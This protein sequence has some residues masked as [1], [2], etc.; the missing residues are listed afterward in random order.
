MDSVAEIT[1]KQ[2]LRFN[3]SIKDVRDV[4]DASQQFALSER[5]KKDNVDVSLV[6]THKFLGEYSGNNPQ[7][8]SVQLVDGKIGEGTI[9]GN[10]I[11]IQQPGREQAILETRSFIEP[12]LKDVKVGDK[13]KVAEEL[14]T[15]LTASTVLHEGVHGMLDS[16]PGSKFAS[17][18]EAVTGFLNEQ[19]RASTLLDEGI[20]YAIQGIYAPEIE[21]IG[22]LA[23]V[24][25]YTDERAIRQRKLLGEKLKP[26][27]KEYIDDG[28]SIDTEFF[29][30]AGQFVIEIQ[31]QDTE[32]E[33]VKSN[34]LSSFSSEELR[35]GA[36]LPDKISTVSWDV[37]SGDGGI[38]ELIE[39]ARAGRPI[40]EIIEEAVKKGSD[41]EVI[42]IKQELIAFFGKDKESE[43]DELLASDN[44][45]SF[46]IALRKLTGREVTTKSKMDTVVGRALEVAAVVSDATDN[47]YVILGSMSM[48]LTLSEIRKV[49]EKLAL[50]DQ[51]ISGGKNDFDIGVHPEKI[52]DTMND[53]GWDDKAQKLRRGKVGINNQTVDMLS[54]RELPHFPWQEVHIGEKSCIV[55]STEEMI[56]EKMML[57]I[58]PGIEE[59]GQQRTREIKWGIDIKLLKTYLR[60]KKGWSEEKVDEHLTRRWDEYM[61]DVGGGEFN[62]QLSYR[63]ASRVAADEY[64]KLIEEQSSVQP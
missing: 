20:A 19:G 23:P 58:K 6:Q 27:V 9:K 37:E 11:E 15:A 32:T 14:A 29:K 13:D 52:S 30:K 55:Q 26:L 34:S 63:E 51:R 24:A 44:P 54:K 28:K 17:D 35:K 41:K 62:G 10:V 38:S 56:F 42:N 60:E 45:S 40:S 57:L 36:K 33:T 43:I 21:P 64:S 1:P 12:L 49:G 2:E 47:K 48:Y 8:F 61:E 7:D 39:Q 5:L 25:R 4:K 3:M 31:T 50:I 53:F 46:E 18:F 22:S 16:K 59:D